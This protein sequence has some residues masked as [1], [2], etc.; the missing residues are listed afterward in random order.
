MVCIPLP[1]CEVPAA[2]FQLVPEYRI[3]GAYFAKIDDLKQTLR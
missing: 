2:G 3:G 1:P